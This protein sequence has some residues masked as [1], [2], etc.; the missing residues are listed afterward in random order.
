[1]PV[2]VGFQA[3]RWGSLSSPGVIEK[4]HV[5]HHRYDIGLG[6]HFLY[7]PDIVFNFEQSCDE[8]SGT[9]QERKSS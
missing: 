3:A 1:L 2:E 9:K 7:G 8:E 4:T 5:D 6:R